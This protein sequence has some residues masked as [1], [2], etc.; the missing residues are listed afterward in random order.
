M[1][2]RAL[3][4]R[5]DCGDHLHRAMIIGVI[6]VDMMQPPV[7]DEIDMA[8]VLHAHMLFARMA[9]GVIIAGNARR[10]LFCVGIG[11]ADIE[12]MFIDV[13]VMGVMQVAIV[14]IVDMARMLHRLMRT[15]LAVG[16]TFVAGV[17]H[18]V[19]G[20]GRSG[21]RKRQGGAKQGSAHQCPP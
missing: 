11:G 5:S 1:A 9:V 10:Q 21:K 16:V 6:A 14:E 8:A 3:T 7:M 4:H 19:R 20:K 15:G 17:K 2:L 13:P 12:R 18:L